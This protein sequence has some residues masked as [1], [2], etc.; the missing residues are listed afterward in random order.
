L[1]PISFFGERVSCVLPEPV[2][3]IRQRAMRQN[4]FG[5]FKYFGFGYHLTSGNIRAPMPSD[6]SRFFR[7]NDLTLCS[8]SL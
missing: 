8:S 1:R 7:A 2:F 6:F 4:R 3:N 5:K